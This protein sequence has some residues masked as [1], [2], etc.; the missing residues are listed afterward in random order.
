MDLRLE[1]PFK[2]DRNYLHG[3]DIHDAVRDAVRNRWGEAEAVDLSFHRLARH[4]LRLRDEAPAQEAMAVC[5]CRA[6]GGA[7]Q[8]WVVETEEPVQGRR[9][10]DEEAV[11]AP[12]QVDHDRRVAVLDG[13][14]ARTDIETWVAMTKRLHQLALPDLRGRWLFVRARLPRFGGAGGPARREI[15]I[16]AVLGNRLTRNELL[17]DGKPAGEIY[18]ALD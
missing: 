2:G 15:R 9:P 1:L 18:F 16:A 7:R 10:Y 12:M 8:L 11:V 6:G 4:A 5:R 14:R 17:L 13:D 3:T